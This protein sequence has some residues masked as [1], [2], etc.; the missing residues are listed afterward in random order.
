MLVLE[1]KRMCIEAIVGWFELFFTCLSFLDI[2]C[3]L[4]GFGFSIRYFYW[5]FVYLGLVVF[6][7]FE[8]LLF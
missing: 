7:F 5:F 6:D 1:I 2:G 4:L 3:F 8:N